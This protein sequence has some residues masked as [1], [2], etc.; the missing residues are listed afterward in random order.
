VCGSPLSGKQ[1]KYCERKCLIRGSIYRRRYKLKRMAV[2]YLGGECGSC[3]YNKCIASLE[4]HHVDPKTKEMIM[5]NMINRSWKRIK[6]ELV[7]CVL[8]C[9]NCHRE[10][11]YTE[12]LKRELL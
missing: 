5:A 7:K 11:H 1:E 8:L 12:K 3:G 4:F 6:K 2:E 9:A 10:L